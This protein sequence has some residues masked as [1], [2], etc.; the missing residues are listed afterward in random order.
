MN[1][2]KREQVVLSEYTTLKTGGSADFVITVTTV[3][4]LTAAVLFAQANNLPLLVLGGG[5]NVLIDDAGFAGVVILMHIMSRVYR[6]VENE[7]LVEVTYGAGE[8][9]DEVIAETVTHGYWGLENLSHIPG[10]IGATPIQN[11]G[12]YGVEVSDLISSVTVY[13]TMTNTV[14]VM[15]PCE[16]VFAYRDSVFKH[17]THRHYIVVAVSFLLSQIPQPKILY[18]DIQAAVTGYPITQSLIR[19][20]IIAIRAQKF[21]DWHTVGTAGSFFKNPIIT[22]VEKERLIML[23]PSLPVYPMRSGYVKVSLGYILDKVCNLKGF[24][25]GNIRLY[26]AQALVLVADVGATTAEILSFASDIVDIVKQKTNIEI[27]CEVTKIFPSLS[28]N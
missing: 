7:E 4:E 12:A 23:Y 11:V 9:L 19:S 15:T 6:R 20:A 3:E 24:R 13:D 27:E 2:L 21:P 26:E 25:K 16:C 8:V 28:K 22:E 18:A 5:S 1:L 10:T 14:C 17:E